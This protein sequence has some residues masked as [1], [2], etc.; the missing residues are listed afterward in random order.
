MPNAVVV[1]RDSV[2]VDVP[3]DHPD[4]PNP[5]LSKK[6]ILRTFSLMNAFAAATL[7]IAYLGV[8]KGFRTTHER[9][10]QAFD[11]SYTM[12]A[13]WRDFNITRSIDELCIA[14]PNRTIVPL[15]EFNVDC[16]HKDVK[17]TMAADAFVNM[18]I[19][20]LYLPGAISIYNGQLLLPNELL[21]ASMHDKAAV[22]ESM[23]AYYEEIHKTPTPDNVTVLF[24]KTLE[25]DRTDINTIQSSTVTMAASNQFT[26]NKETT[27]A[28]NAW[29]MLV[30]SGAM[31]LTALV[32]GILAHCS[33]PEKMGLLMTRVKT[34]FGRVDTGAAAEPLNRNPG[35]TTAY[36]AA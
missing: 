19:Y 11:T 14:T 4:A 7:A 1:E 34:L 17:N 23:R 20:F 10:T 27:Q 24:S 30:G 36:S 15:P 3:S 25:W 35:L 9:T 16:H 12:D 5:A 33:K 32:T 18:A 13:H 28:Y 31:A 6:N 2:L 26:E 21:N 29:G 22:A 8:N